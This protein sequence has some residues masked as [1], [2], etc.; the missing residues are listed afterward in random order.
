MAGTKIGGQKAR[1]ANLKRNPNFYSEIGAK[2]G[3][4]SNNGGF[5][6]TSREN[7]EL[8]RKISAKGGKNGKRQK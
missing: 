3:K 1:E 2:G 6:K 5:Y 7:P 8:H 4:N